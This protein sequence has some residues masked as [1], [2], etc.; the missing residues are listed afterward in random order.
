MDDD[1]TSYSYVGQAFVVNYFTVLHNAPEELH[2]FYKEDSVFC[3]GCS[4]D[5]STVKDTTAIGQE[6]INNAIMSLGFSQCSAHLSVVDCQESIEGSV[7]ILVKGELTNAGESPDSF[8]QTFLLAE[9][10]PSGYYVRNNILRFIKPE[11]K[12]DSVSAVPKAKTK[13]QA[14]PQ[15]KNTP[16]ESKKEERGKSENEEV[17]GDTQ[18]A[19]EKVRQ[20]PSPL[21]NGIA[22][23]APVSPQKAEEKDQVEEPQNPEPTQSES[24]VPLETQDS[25]PEPDQGTADNTNNSE[26]TNEEPREP[27]SSYLAIAA[28]K[29]NDDVVPFPQQPR[30]VVV[31]KPK[32]EE[33]GN[34]G[35]LFVSNLPFQCKESQ[36]EEVMKPFGKITDILIQKGF[37]FVEFESPDSAAASIIA[38]K[39]GELRVGQRVLKIEV[40]RNKPGRAKQ[41]RPRRRERERGR[42]DGNRRGGGRHR[43]GGT[44]GNTPR[45]GATQ[46]KRT[47]SGSGRTNTHNQRR[48]QNV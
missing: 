47:A 4:R 48:G 46:T 43:G 38:A 11:G 10:N 19:E 6:A 32:E 44:Q 45:G 34:H 27:T 18:G 26:S 7:L 29:I 15:S 30:P 23:K 17:G 22:E 3:V 20:D 41:E 33:Q 16:K 2:K 35:S 40:R 9:Q 1:P 12:L 37:A 8:I 39:K 14:K 25:E 42:G 13:G 28:R 21:A 36:I 31:K 24:S 5:N